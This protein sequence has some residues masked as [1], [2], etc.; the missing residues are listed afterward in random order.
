MTKAEAII[1]RVLVRGGVDTWGVCDFDPA[2]LTVPTR[3][4]AR[5]PAEAR[6]ILVAAFP[7]YVG[8]FAHRTL[9]RYAMLPDYHDVVSALLGEVSAALRDAFPAE[10][11]EPFVDISP[12]DEVEAGVRAGLGV[13]GCHTQLI[14]PRYGSYLFLGEIV[15]TLRLPPS[16]PGP[17][18]TACFG[19]GACVRACPGGALDGQGRLDV[20]RCL[21]HLTQKKRLSA[22]EEGAVR[23]GRF[24]WGCDVCGDVCPHNRQAAYS[25]VGAFYRNILAV[26]TNNNLEDA[27]RAWNWRGPEV[28]RRNLRLCGE[29]RGRRN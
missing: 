19:C 25:P 1:G 3:A 10:R 17:Q 8:A 4:L 28:L 9:S 26:L 29:K 27:D 7:Y 6:S 12:L 24:V 2:L 22:E 21:S 5:I 11:F 20:S 13:R 16:A 18:G 15:T 23:C 14:N